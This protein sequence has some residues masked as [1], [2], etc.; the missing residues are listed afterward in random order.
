MV[1]NYNEF[2]DSQLPALKLLQKL[3]WQYIS[4]DQAFIERGELLSNVIL[5]DILTE[6]LHAINHF[7][8][9]G[10]SYKFSTG[11]VQGAINAL[12]SVPIEGV[13]RTNENVYDLLTLGKS[14]NETVNGDR[15]AY[16][17]KFI[18]WQNPENNVY[19]V[20][21][22]F[23]V[24]GQKGKRRPDMVL[25]VNGIP[26]VVIENKRRDKNLSI[27]EAISQNIGNQKDN[28]IPKLFYYAQILIAVQPNAAKYAVTG[29]DA[30]FWA[31]W[32]ED[33]ENEIQKLLKRTVN[34]TQAENRL[35][36]EQDKAL[37]SLCQ[38]ERLLDMV[39]KYIVFD[40]PDKKICRYQQYFAVQETINRVKQ[41]N[42]EGNRKG[43]VIWHTTGSG[44]SLTMVM[45]SKALALEK[46]IENP[47]VIIVT[48]R[49]SLDKQISKTVVNCGK[50]VKKAE[51]GTSL[52]EL[53]PDK[54]SEIIT[55][56]I[57]KFNIATNR[58][59]FKDESQNIF[60]L[61]DESHRSQY[62]S[63]HANMKR[64][65]PNASYIGFTGTPLMKSEKNTSKKFGG[66][67]HKYT[68]D[69]AVKD[70]AVLPLLYEGRSAKLSINKAQIDK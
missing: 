15:K 41:R 43:G 51:S 47:R 40:G 26:F 12:K 19:H 14:F 7:V 45:L 11:S 31:V 17:M 29:T 69:Q 13:V 4:P 70:G 20:T 65:V 57:D 6:Q 10:E 68:I 28:A 60:V 5:N 44:K 33:V 1:A 39:Y 35:V 49:I 32:K 67:I 9:K 37:F 61:V 18:D 24:E 25:F 62:G 63:A 8:Y 30:K 22:E 2:Q 55:T 53:L 48:D 16:T 36:T 46:S 3:N 59:T 56:I 50:S 66:F 64:I 34:N 52:M 42:K 58:V 38:P 23:V 21:D 27:E 54:G